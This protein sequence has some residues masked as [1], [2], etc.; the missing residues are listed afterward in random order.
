[1]AET[2]DISDYSLTTKGTTSAITA[3]VFPYMPVVSENCTLKIGLIGCGGISEA[4]LTAYKKAGF[5]VVALCDK[6]TERAGKRQSKFCPE[7]R[8]YSDYTELLRSPDI[9]VVDIATHPA[10]RVAIIR[11]ALLHDKHV[12][13]QKP[14]VEDIAIG[15]E[16]V[17]L[18]ENRGL[19]LAVNQNGRW[20]PHLCYI[21]NAVRSGILGDI[22][23]IHVAVHWDHTWTIGTSFE[24][25]E[26]LILYDFAI[27]WFDFVSSLIGRRE[28]LRVDATRTKAIGQT[29]K[30][31]L[32]AQCTV[33]FQGGHASL[34]FDGN[35]RDTSYDSTFVA[36]TLGSIRSS[37]PNL[38]EQEM[39][40]STSEGI[41]QPVLTG[42]WFNDGFQGTM[43][44]L[45][46]SIETGSV[47]INN[48]RENLRSLDLCFQA[49]ATAKKNHY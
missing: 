21:R 8:I 18:A 34:V 2:P 19:K 17:E 15:E 38:N 26:D 42:Q 5:Y 29:A 45:L 28:I 43:S 31:A 3:P 36:G 27:H 35:V 46:H 12:L 37:G 11:S 22:F 7:A 41:S 6:F 24:E 4:H 16:L 10:D 40:L 1:M 25:I 49:L 13:S 33:N 32:L 9:D 23:S 48:A 20:A 47:P 14:F 30:P 39:T 44:E